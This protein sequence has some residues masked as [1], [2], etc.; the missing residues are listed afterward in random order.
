VL[1][2]TAWHVLD[3]VLF[4]ALPLLAVAVVVA[5]VVIAVR[6]GRPGR[7]ERIAQRT[8]ELLREQHKG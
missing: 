1:L 8:A 2:P 6:V 4:A 5:V 3:L 7:E